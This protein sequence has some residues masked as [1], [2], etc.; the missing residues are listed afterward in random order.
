MARRAPAQARAPAGSSRENWSD[1][2]RV[3]WDRPAPRVAI[4]MVVTPGW[5]DW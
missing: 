5:P 4:H 3:I 1:F 2:K